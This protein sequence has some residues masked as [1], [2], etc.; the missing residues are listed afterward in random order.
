MCSRARSK[1][2]AAAA[3]S[4]WRS[5]LR[6]A[7]RIFW[8]RCSSARDSGIV[9]DRFHRREGPTLARIMRP[10]A[11]GAE[12]GHRGD[13]TNPYRL[14]ARH[15]RCDRADA[16]ARG[17]EANE[18][19]SIPAPRHGRP[20]SST[21]TASS[22]TTTAIWARSD[23]IRWMPNA[24][25]AIRRLNDAG[26]FVFFFTNQSGVARG[27][28]PKNAQQ[29]CTTGCGRTRSQGARHRRC[30]VLPASSRT[31]RLRLSR[32]PSLAQTEP[33]HDS[34]SDGSIGRCGTKAVLS[35]AIGRPTSRPRKPPASP[36][37]F[38]KAA[39]SMRSSPTS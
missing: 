29:R 15:L 20:P 9:H 32:G 23:R 5:R 38:S 10:S 3:T 4:C 22:I 21:A 2:S 27:F 18:R 14:R 12:R 16:D 35:S 17:R 25:K 33:R 31:D 36:A 34:R 11:C 28:S 7:R 13:S 24:A 8:R 26:Y 30:P 6:A 19:W 1:G 39:I 37:F